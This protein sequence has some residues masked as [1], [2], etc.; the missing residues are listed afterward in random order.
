MRLFLEIFLKRIK[1]NSGV[2]KTIGI[3]KNKRVNTSQEKND[4]RL[5]R[6][7]ANQ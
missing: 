6:P 2:K 3:R 7:L 5:A 4:E 1:E